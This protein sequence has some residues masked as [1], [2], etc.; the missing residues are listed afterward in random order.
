MMKRDRIPITDAEATEWRREFPSLAT[1]VHVAN[2]SH[3]PQSRRVRSAIDAYLESWLEAGMD[4][5]AWMGEVERAREAFARLIGARPGEVAI[6]TS[7]SAAVASVASSLDGWGPR[8]RVVTT[9]AE[10]PTVGHV[11]LAHAKYGLEIDFIPVRDGAIALEDYEE[12]IDE[13]TVLTSATHVYYQNGF[14]Q[15]VGRIAEIAHQAGSL[16]LVDAYQSL[17][18][19]AVDVRELDI[20]ILVG[21]V[22][23]Y[24]LGLPGIAFI[25]VK[26]EIVERFEPALTGWFGRVDPFA[27]D[28]R[29]LDYASEARR[30]D[31]GTPPVFAAVA[32]RA[33]ME[34]IEEVGARRIGERIEELSAYTIEAAGRCGFEYVGPADVNEKGATTAISVPDPHAVEAKLKEGGIVA[35]AR[36]DVIRIAPHFFTGCDDIDRAMAEL[37]KILSGD[38]R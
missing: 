32:A 28:A 25:Y 31:T 21:G 27:F 18:T 36:G 11:W 10:F 2:C 7:A 34:I 37:G 17:G 23:K 19:C 33:G 29:A 20:D 1:T 8:R 24:L 3:G 12:R 26:E 22:L 14:K 9:E 35:S 15:D 4:W 30:F 6:A 16:L 13:R 38:S 5:D